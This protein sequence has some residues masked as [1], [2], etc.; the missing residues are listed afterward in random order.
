[1]LEAIIGSEKFGI[2]LDGYDTFIKDDKDAIKNSD[3]NY[4]DYQDLPD[5]PELNDIIY[6]SDE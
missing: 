5:Y 1:M 6:N 2:V 3:S 4:E